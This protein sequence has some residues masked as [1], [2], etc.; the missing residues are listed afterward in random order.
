MFV[1]NEHTQ[2]LFLPARLYWQKEP[3]SYQYSGAWQGSL[4]LDLDLDDGITKLANLSQITPEDVRAHREK[5]CEPY[6][7]MT[8]PEP[9]CRIL[10]NGEEVCTTPSESRSR[11]YIPE[12]CY[13]DV[14]DEEFFAQ[15]MWN[16]S[17]KFVQRN[18]Y[19]DSSIYTISQHGIHAYDM[20]EEYADISSVEFE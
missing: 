19:L 5:T 1:W 6:T 15:Q 18:L 3:G 14:S 11:E 17:T 2:R 9:V 16:F 4:V 13:V 8:D 7:K 12:Y 10:L 20:D